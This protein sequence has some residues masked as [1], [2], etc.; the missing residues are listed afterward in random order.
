M[1]KKYYA[2]KNGKEIGIFTTWEKCKSLVHGYPNAKYKSFT[3]I[4]EATAYLE[5]GTSIYETKSDVAVLTDNEY[6]AYV[7]GSYNAKTKTYGY[8]AIIFTKD[9][10]LEFNGYGNDPEL[11]EMRNVSGELMGVMSAVDYGI[12]KGANTIKIYYDYM[13]IE[14]WANK[15]WKANK[16]YTKDYVRFIEEKRKKICIKFVKVRAHSGDEYNE[17][18]DKL[19]KKAVGLN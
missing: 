2:V 19:A 1:A 9:D 8:G 11:A 12:E 3:S 18:V 17:K 6:I 15:E 4:E 10:C 5:E 13:G 16:T 14:C 7:D